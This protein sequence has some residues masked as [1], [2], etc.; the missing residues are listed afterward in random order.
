MGN[1]A[2]VVFSDKDWKELSP[3]IYLHWNG[4]PESIYAFLA[5]ME[6][7]EHRADQCYEAA[8]F[9]QLVGEFFDQDKIGTTSLGVANVSG[10]GDLKER[11]DKVRTDPGDNGFY[12]V[13]RE[14][15]GLMVRRFVEEY[16]DEKGE[17]Y[18]DGARLVEVHDEKVRRERDEAVKH[19][20]FKGIGEWFA[21]FR[22][23]KK[24]E[25]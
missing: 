2:N 16:R 7:R 15:G 17:P 12:V 3:A 14:G 11:L 10:E 19:E 5:E 24:I 20:T 25:A 18:K 22:V 4:G 1:R 8:R 21:G 6:V 23:G 13:C 9:I